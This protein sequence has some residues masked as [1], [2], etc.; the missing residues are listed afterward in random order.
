M[1]IQTQMQ[2]NVPVHKAYEAFVNPEEISGF[3]FSHSSERWETGKT[4]TLKYAEYN[5]ELDIEIVHIEEN[6]L[7]QFTWGNHPVDIHFEENDNGVIVT[8][9]EQDF[10][11]TEVEQLLGQK[12]GWVYM[13]SCLKAYLE[14]NVKIRAALL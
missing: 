4:I 6:R 3:W 7:I 14:Y 5:A 10:D 12:E 8:T 9:I 1:D 2:I 13:L 11:K